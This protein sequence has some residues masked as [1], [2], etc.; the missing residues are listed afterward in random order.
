MRELHPQGLFRM[1]ERLILFD[2][3]NGAGPHNIRLTEFAAE[4]GVHPSD[5]MAE[6][7][8][9]N[10]LDSTIDVEP[11]PLVDEVITKL[12]ADPLSVGNISDTPAHGQMFCGAGRNMLLFT[13]Y[14]KERGMLSLEEAVY[15]QTGKLA[16][17]FNLH[18]IGE[19][20]AGK[21]ADIAVIS[22]ENIAQQP[23]SD[24]YAALV[25]SSNARD[26][27]MTMVAGKRIY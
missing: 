5:A 27:A 18:Q 23:V 14:M 26:V 3:E 16:Q 8:L 24:I 25:F 19:I 13:T 9:R 6:W 12:F 15:V 22:L 21:Q 10:G 4:L 11:M 7:F 2:S 17:H 1:P 20:K